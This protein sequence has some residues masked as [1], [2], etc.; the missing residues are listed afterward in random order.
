[1][2][3]SRLLPGRRGILFLCSLC[4]V[5]HAAEEPQK[6]TPFSYSINF[7]GVAPVG[8]ASSTY[9]SSIMVGGGVSLPVGRWVSVDLGSV[10]FG[11]GTADAS[12]TISVNDEA[13]AKGRKRTCRAM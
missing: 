5:A 4:A 3:M 2:M 7:G 13:C 11:F 6:H 1:M 10:D 12:R 9:K 8:A